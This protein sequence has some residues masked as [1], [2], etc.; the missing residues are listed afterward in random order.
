MPGCARASIRTHRCGHPPRRTAAGCAARTDACCC[1]VTLNLAG[2]CA[3]N[4]A[5]T[6]STNGSCRPYRRSGRCSGRPPD[7]Q[8]PPRTGRHFGCLQRLRSAAVAPRR[9]ATPFRCPAESPCSASHRS[10]PCQGKGGRQ[11]TENPAGA[12]S[13]ARTRPGPPFSKVAGQV[14][15]PTGPHT[16]LKSLDNDQAPQSAPWHYPIG[17]GACPG[18]TLRLRPRESSGSLVMVCGATRLCDAT[19][20]RDPCDLDSGGWVAVEGAAA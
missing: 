8:P 7:R 20:R 15:T 3:A 17:Q 1:L 6:R 5:L 14:R 13:S 2:G 18:P 19:S 16:P 12:P 10:P 9:A 11:M 4:T